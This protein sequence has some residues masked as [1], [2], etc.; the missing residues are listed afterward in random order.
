MESTSDESVI[1][2]A[3]REETTAQSLDP[4]TDSEIDSKDPQTESAILET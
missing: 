2:Q 3:E 4:F 1:E